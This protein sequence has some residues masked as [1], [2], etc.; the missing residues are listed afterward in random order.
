M[1]DTPRIDADAPVSA[2]V[3]VAADDAD[4]ADGPRLRVDELGLF[5]SEGAVEGDWW[6]G[7]GVRG[8]VVYERDG[9]RQI[10]GRF[11]ELGVAATLWTRVDGTFVGATPRCQV[12]TESLSPEVGAAF[13]RAIDFAADAGE[14][15][16]FFEELRRQTGAARPLGTRSTRDPVARPAEN[17]DA[18]F[19]DGTPLLAWAPE[20]TLAVRFRSVEAAFRFA[21]VA[22]R[23]AERLGFAAGIA[24]DHGSLRLTL[25]HLLL[26]S[27]W[28]ANPGGPKGVAECMLIVAEKQSAGAL[29]VAL[30]F[31]IVDPEL[32]AMET[33]AGVAL[34][35]SADHLWRPEEDPFPKLRVRRAVRAVVGDCE[36]VA[37]SQE[38]LE[39]VASGETQPAKAETAGE[40]E[41]EL[42]TRT[43]LPTPRGSRRA[44]SLRGAPIRVDY[45]TATAR[46]YLG[47]SKLAARFSGFGRIGYM[48]ES[49][50]GGYT[51]EPWRSI[52]A[53]CVDTGIDG[54][55]VS[56]RLHDEES[57]VALADLLRA[58]VPSPEDT[59]A[60][61]LENLDDLVALGM[62]EPRAPD[63]AERCFVW[64]G[65]RPVCPD[66]G[67]YR[68]H[69][70]TGE[71]KC[72][73]HGT[74]KKPRVG[75]GLGPSPI[76][77]VEIDGSRVTFLLR[78]DWS[79]GR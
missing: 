63:V 9:R 28:G 38:M 22:D 69:P 13:A 65:W 51:F 24:R 17:R 53:A 52:V 60:L 36:V 26:P 2:V 5:V 78:I 11:A 45:F 12:V 30:V 1:E 7:P 71:P 62:V 75:P 58:P 19:P 34:E 20:G 64:M 77:E 40:T 68:F 27:I 54:A 55:T 31:R 59:R 23:L 73:V 3:P 6:A 49:N 74:E 15:R 50:R 47:W 39:R 14:I 46:S 57:A 21:D 61:C 4:G 67:T 44:F 76:R 37:T 42:A 35:T 32:H 43:G 72:T 70:V 8:V 56:V 18:R 41:A 10:G 79:R 25:H 29:D 33:I 48:N 66:G 16:P